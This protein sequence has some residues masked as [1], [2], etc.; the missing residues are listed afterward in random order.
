EVVEDE[1][2][3]V[4][5]ERIGRG[6]RHD[7]TFTR[8]GAEEGDKLEGVSHLSR[9]IRESSRCHDE[10]TCVAREARYIGESA[11]S[12]F[13]RELV[14]PVEGHVAGVAVSGKPSVPRAG[15]AGG[16]ALEQP[17]PTTVSQ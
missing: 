15:S 1:L 6:P 14:R 9:N 13:C 5:R 4:A 12:Q 7:A 10:I 8:H 11:G 2:P 3:R 16:G 17:N